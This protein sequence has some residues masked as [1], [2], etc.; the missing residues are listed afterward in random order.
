MTL[1]EWLLG[2][3]DGWTLPLWWRVRSRITLGVSRTL[4]RLRPANATCNACGF[5]GRR[6]RR[7]IYC[8]ACY[9][10]ENGELI[11]MCETAGRI[12]DLEYREFHRSICLACDRARR[13]QAVSGG[14]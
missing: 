6:T 14:L 3:G 9:E 1:H 13:T 11:R 5:R 2:S 10:D 4:Y 8:P 7:G 12:D